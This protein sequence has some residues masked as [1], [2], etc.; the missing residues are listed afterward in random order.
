MKYFF[1]LIS[2]TCSMSFANK[3][4]PN[5][6]KTTNKNSSSQL[7]T[8]IK[9]DGHQVGGKI[10]APFEALAEVENEKSI[11]QL[12]QVR[13]NFDDRRTKAKLMR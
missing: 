6:S 11:D 13:Q 4:H 10:Q 3:T 5:K 9:F 7:S 1:I 12:I 8:D 2:I